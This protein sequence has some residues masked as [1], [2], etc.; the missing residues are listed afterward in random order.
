ML[1]KIKKYLI[2]SVLVAFSLNANSG[3][4]SLLNP[5]HKPKSTL[6]GKVIKFGAVVAAVGVGSVV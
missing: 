1:S 4:L 5:T 2:V 3:R 6:G